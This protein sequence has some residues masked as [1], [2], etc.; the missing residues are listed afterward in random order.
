MQKTQAQHFYTAT[1]NAQKGNETFLMLV[2]EGLTRN[3]L[4]RLIEKRPSLYR[5]FAGWL[6][7][8]PA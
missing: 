8:L 6:D 2:R 4:E 3:E 7:K 1:E 5:R